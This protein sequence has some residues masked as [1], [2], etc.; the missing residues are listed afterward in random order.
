MSIE[1]ILFV[2][3]GAVAIAAAVAMLLT[4]NAVHSALFL[5]LNFGCI[6]FLF[7]ML[8]A[9]FLAMV[10]IAVY[11]GAIMVL[12][13]FVIMLLGAEKAALEDIRQ[14]NWLAP[15]ALTLALSFLIAVSIALIT[16]EIDTREVPQ[17]PPLLRVA[18]LAPGYPEAVDIYANGELIASGIEF[19]DVTEFETAAAGEYTVSI[20]LEGND[21]SVALPLSG[22]VNIDPATANTIVVYGE[23]R[24]P[25]VSTITE[26]LASDTSD[27]ARVILF[28]GYTPVESL[29]FIDPGSDFIISDGEEIETVVGELAFGASTDILEYEEG[30]LNGVFVDSADTDDFLL[31][32]RDYELEGSTSNLLLVGT[33]TGDDGET[34]PLP[35]FVA[36]ALTPLF[37]SP[38]A[39]G[40]SLFTDYVLPFQIVAMLLLA[41]MV[42]AIVLTQ[43]GDVKP[44]PGRPTRRRVSRPL[45]SVI[46]SQT[47]QDVYQPPER[48]Q[49]TTPEEPEPAGD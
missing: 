28:N 44:K 22:A 3:V 48:P 25:V 33:E 36:T 24:Q 4:D 7:L 43:R 40:R 19:R 1:V 15:A 34:R 49:L 45:T 46:A 35:V 6:A 41:A 11:A 23:G 39:I 27:D 29:D 8:D 18:H 14:F 26:E 32:I 5:I 17:D 30:E 37:G 13:L 38:T 9:S 31:T 42:G 47:G 21:A 10:Q 16:G 2:V 20:T 12:F